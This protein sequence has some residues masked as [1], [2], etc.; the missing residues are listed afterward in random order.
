MHN[1]RGDDSPED[2]ASSREFAGMTF[3]RQPKSSLQLGGAEIV[4][5]DKQRNIAAVSTGGSSLSLVSYRKG[6]SDPKAIGELELPGNAQSVAINENGL[7]A[8]ALAVNERNDGRIHFY[9]LDGKSASPKG[10]VAVGNLPDSISFTPDGNTLIS[11][12]EGEPNKFYGTDDGVDPEGSI[13]V[14]RIDARK[15]GRS[16]VSTLKFGNYSTDELRSRGVRISGE[17]PTPLQDIEPE[18]VS[19]SPNG[20]DA[21]ITLQENNAI[22]RVDIKRRKIKDIFSQGLKDWSGTDLDTTDEDSTYAPG[23]RNVV[24]LRMADG[25]DT[26]RHK[27]KTYLITANEGDGRVRPDDVNFEASLADGT[28]YSY[29]DNLADGVLAEIEDELTGANLYVYA[30]PDIGNRGNFDADQGDEFF[31]T[32][33]YGPVSDDE[34]YSDEVRAGKLSTGDGTLINEGRLK[35]VQDANDPITGLKGF[36]G[37]SFTIYDA[38][39]NLVYDSG[40]LLDQITNAAGFYDDDRSD[41]KS[42]EP[43]SV[44]TASIQGRRFAFIGLERPYNQGDADALGTFIPVFEITKPNKPSY[45]GAFSSAESLSPEGLSWVAGGN[46]GGHLLAANEV[47]GSLDAFRFHLGML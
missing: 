24:G 16:K 26:F 19:I 7:I 41:D 4:A 8:V 34:F 46:R 29:G 47:S 23:P 21:F 15:P 33:N 27:G 10:S 36:G 18:Y 9:Q 12:N 45:V 44:V 5:Y 3:L 14:V 13:S 43:E 38:K 40:N 37:R 30:A 22:A 35:T 11:A 2:P 28:I 42:I 17:N 6:F 20:R 1:Q 25:I 32:L 31:I 39:G